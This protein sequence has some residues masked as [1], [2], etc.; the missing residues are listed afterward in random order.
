MDLAAHH[1]EVVDRRAEQGDPLTKFANALMGRDKSAAEGSAQAVPTGPVVRV[2]RGN[3]V[4]V[5]PVGAR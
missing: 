1:T 4:T 2:S 3:S 5:V